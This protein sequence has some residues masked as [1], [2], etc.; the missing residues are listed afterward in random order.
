MSTIFVV[1]VTTNGVAEAAAGLSIG[2]NVTTAELLV[3]VNARLTFGRL[4]VAGTSAAD[5]PEGMLTTW[6]LVTDPVVIVGIT[7]QL[8]YRFM[9]ADEVVWKGRVIAV[10]PFVSDQPSNA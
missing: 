2:T 9:L 8:A 3:A 1:P 7:R 5:S 4:D 6:E 10:P